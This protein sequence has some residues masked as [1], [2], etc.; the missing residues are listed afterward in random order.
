MNTFAYEQQ[1]QAGLFGGQYG[2]TMPTLGFQQQPQYDYGGNTFANQAYGEEGEQG[3]GFG[4]P[5]ANA[6]QFVFYA[7]ERNDTHQKQELNNA[8]KPSLSTGDEPP[9]GNVTRDVQ[10]RQRRTKSS[11][12]WCC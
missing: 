11:G 1:G 2:L 10:L 9:V 5:M 4:F 12:G 7:E 8:V 3:Q 6:G